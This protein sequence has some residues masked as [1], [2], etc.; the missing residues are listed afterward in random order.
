[1][2]AYLRAALCGCGATIA[3]GCSYDYDVFGSPAT[4]AGSSGGPTSSTTTSAGAGGS[5]AT[6]ATGSG[7][8]GASSSGGSGGSGPCTN[9]ALA[10]DGDDDRVGIA[11]SAALNGLPSLTVEAWIN[12]GDG[13]NNAERHLVSH[14]DHD[15]RTGWMLFVI[16]GQLVF[17]IYANGEFFDDVRPIEPMANTWHHVAGVLEA[18]T[19]SAYFDG[20]RMGPPTSLPVQ[21][22]AP[23]SGRSSIGAA[24]ALDADWWDGLIDEVRISSVARYTDD[25]QV[26]GTSFQLDANTLA[27]LHFDEADGAQVPIDAAGNLDAQLGDGPSADDG[28]PS[29]VDVPCIE[30][31]SSP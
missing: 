17:R 19:L 14:G 29:R 22:A 9:R 2:L 28:D 18:Q 8:A 13:L 11:P 24:A 3:V 23:Y 15:E 5:G 1:M 21:G 7:G 4:A 26:P 16:G 20:E 10:F 27:L 25:F 12:V 31:F 30:R 6:G